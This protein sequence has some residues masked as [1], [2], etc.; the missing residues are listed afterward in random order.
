MAISI[1]AV[2]T[3]FPHLDYYKTLWKQFR[4]SGLREGFWFCNQGWW[5]TTSPEN[6]LL[7]LATTSTT[8]SVWGCFLSKQ[9]KHLHPRISD[10]FKNNKCL[11]GVFTEPELL[12]GNRRMELSSL[13]QQQQVSI[14]ILL[15]GKISLSSCSKDEKRVHQDSQLISPKRQNH[16]GE[17]WKREKLGKRALPCYPVAHHDDMQRH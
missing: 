8:L 7:P 6:K 13:E 9:F 16:A 17:C 5:Q 3:G 1:S 10:G 2:N 14:S 11:T 15:G 12:K 4:I